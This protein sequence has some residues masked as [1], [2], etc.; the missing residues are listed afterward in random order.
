MLIK[1]AKETEIYFFF[2]YRMYIS[3]AL[4]VIQCY[5]FSSSFSLIFFI[6][7]FFAHKYL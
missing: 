7:F 1:E 5:C 2:F 3:S 4:L 6:K